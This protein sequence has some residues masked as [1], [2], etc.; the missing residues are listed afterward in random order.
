[1]PT[2]DRLSAEALVKKLEDYSG[3]LLELNELCAAKDCD[4]CRTRADRASFIGQAAALLRAREAAEQRAEAAE[5]KLRELLQEVVEV[6][7]YDLPG[8]KTCGD[9]CDH[10]QRARAASQRCKEALSTLSPAP[11]E[12]RS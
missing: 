4:G 11:E 5:A 2:D 9:D 8:G 7:D 3:H 1:M 12:P 6:I 10:C